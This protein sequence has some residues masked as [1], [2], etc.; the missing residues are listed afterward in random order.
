MLVG[1]SLSI[2]KDRGFDLS[3]ADWID[4]AN[5]RSEAQGQHRLLSWCAYPACWYPADKSSVR[6]SVFPVHRTA[7]GQ[8]M[9]GASVSISFRWTDFAQAERKGQRI[10]TVEKDGPAAGY[11]LGEW[12]WLMGNQAAPPPPFLGPSL[13]PPGRLL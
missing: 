9:I 6:C 7:L 11:G 5:L 4:Q 8:R 12:R 3:L 1:A 13:S 2:T 10:A